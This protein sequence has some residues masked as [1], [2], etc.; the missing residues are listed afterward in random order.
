MVP[1][2]ER[3]VRRTYERGEPLGEHV[4]AGI[5]RMRGRDSP[6]HRRKAGAESL[7]YE[8][9]DIFEG[10][11]NNLGLGL[12][13]MSYP[14]DLGSPPGHL[15]LWSSSRMGMIRHRTS[16]IPAELPGGPGLPAHPL[17]N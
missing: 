9:L 3:I 4:E 5:Q 14:Q 15:C 6:E 10:Q 1:Y 16:A 13:P 12:F 11:E 8:E 2:R 7:R 17:V